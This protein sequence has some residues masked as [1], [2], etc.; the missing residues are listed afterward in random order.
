MKMFSRLGRSAVL[1]VR[2]V[3]EFYLFS[4]SVLGR[5]PRFY[6]I[7]GIIKSVLYRQVLFTGWD[8]LVLIG[9]IAV[10]ISV[11]IVLEVNQ[12]MGQMGKGRLIYQL[13]VLIVVHQLSSLLTALVVIARS[14]TAISTELGNMVVNHEIDLLHSFGISPFTYLVVPR[15]AGVVIS[16]FTL[17]LYFNLIAVVGGALFSNLAYGIHID[18]FITRFLRELT[19]SDLFSPV[20]KSLLFGFAVGLVT[21]YQ[22]LKVSRAS[23]EVPQRTMHAVVNAVVAVIFLNILVT[24]LNYR[25]FNSF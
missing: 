8:A 18:D 13:L 24:L 15:V 6:K 9:F 3:V 19:F 20:I 23:T 5:L 21:C 14:G 16:I 12:V 4:L 11:L 10:S 7:K 22:G 2:G 25:Q 1:K 17:T